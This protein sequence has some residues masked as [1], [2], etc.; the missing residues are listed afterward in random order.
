MRHLTQ[1]VCA[2][3]LAT[4]TLT[5]QT[6]AFNL[7]D[8]KLP[9]LKRK[10]LTVSGDLNGSVY[11]STLPIRERSGSNNNKMTIS[12]LFYKNSERVQLS[13]RTTVMG[14]FSSNLYDYP[15]QPLYHTISRGGNIEQDLTNRYYFSQWRY[16]EMGVNLYAGAHDLSTAPMKQMV[17]SLQS[18][19]PIKLGMG[20]IERIE[21]ARH[22]MY[23]VEELQKAGRISQP[24]TD[25]DMLALSHLIAEVKNKRFFDSRHQTIYELEAVDSFLF[26]RNYVPERDARYFA[27][28]SDNWTFGG[29]PQRNCGSR[30]ALATYTG[31]NVY[32]E[33]YSPE[34]LNKE[35]HTQQIHAGIEYTNEKPWK[36]K[37]QSTLFTGLYAGSIAYRENNTSPLSDLYNRDHKT[38]EISGG[39]R[40]SIGLYPSTRTSMHIY[41]TL[42]H[43]YLTR[44]GRAYQPNKGAHMT[45]ATAGMNLNY[46]ISPRLRLYANAYFEYSHSQAYGLVLPYNNPFSMNDFYVNHINNAYN[47]QLRNQ[48]NTYYQVQLL[49]SIF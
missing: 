31:Y 27:T 32:T 41:S 22:A 30:Y 40:Y 38:P 42:Y 25:E 8:F 5:A 9:N 45:S 16:L 3:T 43:M 6:P 33:K 1:L 29:L 19:V 47:N 49:Y 34:D 13:S 4:G 39:I 2:L 7:S 17:H 28:L 24:V 20:R 46:Y 35:N 23:I 10:V 36:K 15:N 11:G 37:W 44:S 48:F 21:D 18:L 14:Y 26:A 12:Y